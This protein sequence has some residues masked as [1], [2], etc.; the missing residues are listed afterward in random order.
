MVA[1]SLQVN[2]ATEDKMD[3]V[4]DGA[5]TLDTELKMAEPP[6]DASKMSNGE[7]SHRRR[8]TSSRSLNG[9][10]CI[11]EPSMRQLFVLSANDKTALNTQVDG[12]CKS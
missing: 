3:A 2:G 8:E 5:S 7:T 10:T 12:I 4:S 1:N 11:T 6:N 9:K